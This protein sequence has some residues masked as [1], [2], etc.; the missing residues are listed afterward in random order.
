[1]GRLDGKRAL[2]T[3]R[4]AASAARSRAASR[5]RVRRSRAAAAILER[6]GGRRTRSEPRRPRV[7]ALGDVS[8]P[9][10]AE[11]VVD[12]ASG[13]RWARRVVCNAGI[14]AIEWADRRRLGRRR[15]RPHHHDQPARPVPR[16]AR[17]DPAHA[18]RRQ[19]ARSCIC[20]AS[21]RSPSGPATAATTSRRPAST[22]SPTTSRSST[23]RVAFAPTR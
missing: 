3:G 19:A 8:T 1:M 18:R 4:R 20:R 7:A 23:D 16:R 15:V 5:A 11:V 13:A 17:R 2:V 14:D 9:E 12:A 6:T 22:C 21:A 10:S